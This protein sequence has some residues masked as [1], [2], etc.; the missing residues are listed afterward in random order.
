MTSLAA[1]SPSY[2]PPSLPSFPNQCLLVAP[3]L[4]LLFTST[5]T[6]SLG[7]RVEKARKAFAHIAVLAG[8]AGILGAVPGLMKLPKLLSGGVIEKPDA[9]RIQVRSFVFVC[10]SS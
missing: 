2:P 3:T 10:V 5:G 6:C 1:A 4:S 9:A 8:V 7:V